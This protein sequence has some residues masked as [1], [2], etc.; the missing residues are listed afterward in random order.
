MD[1][2]IKE[3]SEQITDEVVKI[4]SS[5]VIRPGISHLA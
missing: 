4:I 3:W 5:E 1:T 2:C